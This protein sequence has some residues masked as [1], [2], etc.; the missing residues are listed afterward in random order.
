MPQIDEPTTSGPKTV[1]EA[2]KPRPAPDKA[3]T[4]K[5]PSGLYAFTV[6]TGKGSIVTIEKID[7]NTRQMLTAAEKAQLAKQHDGMSLRQLV[8]QAFEAGIECVLGDGGATAKAPE[9]KQESELSSVVLQS[10]IEGSKTRELVEPAALDRTII[11]S[12]FTQAAK[13]AGPVGQ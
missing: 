2:R 3:A 9:S 4:D 10:L 11:S 6:D 5:A 8:E 13:T 7:H 12:L 1:P